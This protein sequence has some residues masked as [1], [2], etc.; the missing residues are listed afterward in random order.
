MLTPP[1]GYA[2]GG[3]VLSARACRTQRD[4]LAESSLKVVGSPSLFQGEGQQD[5]LLGCETALQ[6]APL[7][8]LCAQHLP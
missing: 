7:S 6:S 5:P 2:Q 1:P 4:C 3:W 8:P